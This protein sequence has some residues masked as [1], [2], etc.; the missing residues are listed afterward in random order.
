MFSHSVR[1]LESELRNDSGLVWGMAHN[2]MDQTMDQM[3]LVIRTGSQNGRHDA[4][5][6]IVLFCS[7]EQQRFWD[8]CHV[9]V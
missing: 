8:A 7:G 9:T 6:F 2:P 3:D 4:H 5:A 1:T